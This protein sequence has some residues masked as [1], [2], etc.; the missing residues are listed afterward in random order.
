LKKCSKFIE[1]YFVN[2]ENGVNF[3]LAFGENPGLK[4]KTEVIE[5]LAT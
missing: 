3:A 1:K 4:T 5:I 2:S